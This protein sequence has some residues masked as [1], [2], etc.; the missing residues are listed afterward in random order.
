VVWEVKGVPWISALQ[1]RLRRLL[2][3]EGEGR[4]RR[5]GE[6]IVYFFAIAGG[7]IGIHTRAREEH[8]LLAMAKAEIRG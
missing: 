3:K 2:L 5:T 6:Y 4:E 8:L 7:F 1:W